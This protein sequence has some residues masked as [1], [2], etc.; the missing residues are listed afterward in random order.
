[1]LQSS[2]FAAQEVT[3]S[4]DQAVLL[5]LVVGACIAIAV[6]IAMFASK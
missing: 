2:V 5:V 3:L 4:P 1:M 6:A